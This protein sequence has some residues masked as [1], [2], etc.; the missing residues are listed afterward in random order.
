[1][2]LLFSAFAMADFNNF[3]MI[4]EAYLGLYSKI[5][6]AV[7][8]SLP[9][10]ASSTKHRFVQANSL[11]FTFGGGE[12][13][14]AVSLANYGLDAAFVTK[15]PAHPAADLRPAP[16]DLRIQPKNRMEDKL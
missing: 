2:P 3:P 1:M 14:V 4:S 12:A 7:S 6:K 9:L 11:E 5:P 13:N 15:L 16:F 10:M 8:T